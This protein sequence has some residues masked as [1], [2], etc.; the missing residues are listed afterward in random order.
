[1]AGFMRL[2]RMGLV[3]F[4]TQVEVVSP[5][6]A[7]REALSRRIGELKADG[8][9]ALYD[10][11]WTGVRLVAD[12]P[13]TGLRA[14]F[15]ITDGKDEGE[16]PPGTP[17]SALRL[18]PLRQALA[19]AGVPLFILGLGPAAE[20]DLL[21]SLATESGGK[22][23][24][25]ARPE[26]VEAI[27]DRLIA[28]L[29]A[30]R[31]VSYVSPRPAPDGT[32]RQVEAT[33]LSGATWHGTY[34]APR[35][36]A[37]LWRWPVAASWATNGGRRRAACG[38]GALSPAGTWALAAAPLT[39]LHGDGAVAAAG[40]EDPGIR[41]ER[42]R[43]LDDGSGWLFAG[44]LAARFSREAGELRSDKEAP[45]DTVAVSP[46]GS[47]LLRLV[48]PTAGASTRLETVQTGSDVPLWSVPCPGPNCDRLAGA[49]V[50]DDGVVLIN[51][52]GTL[53]RIDANGNMLPSRPQL[54]FSP[55]S[56]TADGRLAAA[57][58]WQE[59]HGGAPR[60]LLLDSALRDVLTLSVQAADADVPPLAVVSPAGKYFAVLDDTRLRGL[61]L[62]APA[63]ERPAWRVLAYPTPTPAPCER[64]LQLDDKGRVLVSDGDS[65]TL[66]RGLSEP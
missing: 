41:V 44:T 62:D 48:I 66:L 14:V 52:T 53:Y 21:E 30:A 27:L 25:A 40:M 35:Q 59:R 63:G 26:E 4:A 22:A 47:Y 10:A 23:V 5:A 8:A 51:Q 17:G 16:G 18:E 36:E 38:V 54:F 20:R 55:V 28:P 19:T 46:G 42:A 32:R 7:D 50:S 45:H 61:A 1:M 60:A 3:R 31:G 12:A 57:V 39:L 15:V 9:T 64:T 13:G 34:R 49:A 11:V 2:H 24:F 33:A 6:T 29:Y 56:L 58:V 65:L 37:V 43:S